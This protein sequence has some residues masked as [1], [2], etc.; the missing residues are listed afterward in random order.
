MGDS[1]IWP[2][3]HAGEFFS[4][5][6]F[7]SMHM[8]CSNFE[9]C[10]GRLVLECSVLLLHQKLG[11]HSRPCHKNTILACQVH[12]NLKRQNPEVSMSSQPMLRARI[13]FSWID[14]C[15]FSAKFSL[16][17]CTLLRSFQDIISGWTFIMWEVVSTEPT[18]SKLQTE[19]L[20]AWQ[21]TYS[22]QI[23]SVVFQQPEARWWHLLTFSTHSRKSQA[24]DHVCATFVDSQHDVVL[25]RMWLVARVWSL[26]HS[27]FVW[28]VCLLAH[29]P[30][31]FPMFDRLFC[32]VSLIG[33]RDCAKI[34]SFDL[35]LEKG[36]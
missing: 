33:G 22:T 9:N 26:K 20:T 15:L 16:L 23:M 30:A 29:Y 19:W 27:W 2:K 14:W 5:S 6:L 3:C 28:H 12:I 13:T 18:R 10:K 8:S 31:V 4:F 25:T 1:S 32:I 17:R 11:A 36:R 34:S 21:E 35:S 24:H 7:V